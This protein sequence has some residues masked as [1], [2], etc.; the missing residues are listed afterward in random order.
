MT[1]LYSLPRLVLAALFV[2]VASGCAS[3]DADMKEFIGQPSSEL[4][5]RLGT[6]QLRAPNPAG[7]ETWSYLSES[8]PQS[9]AQAGPSFQNSTFGNAIGGSPAARSATSAN[10]FTSRREFLIDGQGRVYDYHSRGH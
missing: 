1:T 6:P 2:V 4:L 8:G 5:T 7:G 9:M 3:N 10:G